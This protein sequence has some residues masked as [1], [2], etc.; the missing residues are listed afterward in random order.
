MPN[1]NVACVF[2]IDDAY[3]MPFQ[4]LFHSLEVTCSIPA[5]AQVFILHSESLC[6]ESISILQSFFAL[7]KR[8]VIFLD[9]S[10]Y[11][12]LVLPIKDGDH[13]SQATFYRLFIADIIPKT[14]DRA[15][16][17]DSD[18]IALKSVASLF[19]SEIH[20]FVGAVDHCDPKEGL[21]LW[22]ECG[23]PYFQ[24]GVLVIPLNAWRE[25]NISNL[26][27]HVMATEQSRIQWW[28]Q[29][30]LNIA[31]R[32]SWHALPVWFNICEASARTLEISVS[33]PNISLIHL[34]G[35]RKPWKEFNPPSPFTATWDNGFAAAF[36]TFFDRKMFL[37]RR[38]TR[39]KNMVLSSLPDWIMRRS[40]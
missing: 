12:P 1:M 25:K 14:F 27:L 39:F 33:D 29:D 30:V 24:A 9:P 5:D 8:H 4:V 35:A 37:P 26:F 11:M 28:D 23:G 7:Y 32:D 17:F 18:M 40:S 38:R 21:R 6:A 34:S 20:G 13:V 2:S 10:S 22:G 36:G 31:L 16:Y 15:V 19:V 3:V